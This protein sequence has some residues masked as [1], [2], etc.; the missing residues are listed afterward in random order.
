MY[1]VLEETVPLLPED[2]RYLMGLASEALIEGVIR[3]VDMSTVWPTTLGNG[4]TM[5]SQG[6]RR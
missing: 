1:R 5:T 3:G 2:N 6:R 4:T